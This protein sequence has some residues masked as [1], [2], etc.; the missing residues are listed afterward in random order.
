MTDI[1]DYVTVFT[2]LKR[3]HGYNSSDEETS[4]GV[5]RVQ[6]PSFDY[7]DIS[8]RYDTAPKDSNHEVFLTRVLNCEGIV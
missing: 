3:Q 1:P 6:S 2:K 4:R 8:M 7:E 5:Q